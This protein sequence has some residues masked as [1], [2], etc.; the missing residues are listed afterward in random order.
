MRAQVGLAATLLLA[1]C[2][3]S[4]SG[5][6]PLAPG[7]SDAAIKTDA[8]GADALPET[9]DGAAPDAPGFIP[10][11]PLLISTASPGR[12]EDPFVLR[13]RDGWIYVVWFSERTGNGDIYLRRTH[14]GVAW[15]EAVRVSSTAER[16]L[17]P[18]L[19]EDDAGRLHAAWFRR[20]DGG[21]GRGH[22]VYT[23]TS[24]GLA[25]NPGSEVAVTAPAGAD[26]DWTPSIVRAANGALV[27]AFARDGCY[28]RPQ[29]CF[30]LKVVTSDDGVVWSNPVAMVA[31]AGEQDHL[32]FLARD[33]ANL[34]AVYN[35]YAANA[36][37]PYATDTTD[38][39]SAM[40]TD[41]MTWS[42]PAE[43]TANDAERVVDVFPI[44]F[45]DHDLTQRMLWLS[46][47]PSSQSVVERAF[48][49]S[50]A[51]VPIDALPASG[52]SHHVVAT[53]TP[54]VYLGA[55]VEGAEPAQEIRARVFRR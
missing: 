41:G 40:S 36:T 26:N 54:G 17:Y 28:P 34:I 25:W 48:S 16:D 53:P 23:S 32:P 44:L 14:D 43:L 38:V 19:H 31:P 49:G 35:R 3:E 22:I 9:G 12:D 30:T 13:A 24:D 18:C 1:A 27:I 7:G 5:L 45:T 51:P 8:T 10:A 21:N 20:G 2:G 52:Y 42:A 33:G 15:S 55:W 37:L 6:A 11:D 39:L 50:G 4:E 46:A 47:T 29:P